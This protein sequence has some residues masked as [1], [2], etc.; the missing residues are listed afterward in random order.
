MGRGPFRTR[1]S[2]PLLSLLKGAGTGYLAAKGAQAEAAEKKKLFDL[3]KR[4][5]D[6]EEEYKKGL[7][8]GNEADRARKEREFKI[9]LLQKRDELA[10]SQWL[11]RK[12]HSL[13]ERAQDSLD[14]NRKD[15]V[16]IR[17]K[18]YGVTE[19]DLKLKREDQ[20]HTQ[21]LEGQN[22]ELDQAKAALDKA[23]NAAKIAEISARIEKITEDIAASKAAT[24]LA[25]RKQGWIEGAQDR[26]DLAANTAFLRK[27]YLQDLGHSQAQELAKL[28]AHL[29]SPALDKMSDSQKFQINQ[30]QETFKVAHE[31]KNPELANR[32][33]EQAKEISKSLKEHGV[34]WPPLMVTVSKKRFW[35]DDVEVHS[36]PSTVIDQPQTQQW[37]VEN[38]IAA[39]KKHGETT[40]TPKDIADMKA[41][42]MSD[43]DIERVKNAFQK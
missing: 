32:S 22:L 34:E 42:G 16:D 9:N 27:K 31:T 14:Q 2:S 38:V 13:A 26:E 41:F 7:I 15:I 29:R 30:W 17:T 12:K 23:D 36:G 11:E 5:L 19:A 4:E 20:K 21:W 37:T 24:L 3:K 1:R 8:R 33:N 18:E 25:E 39:K 6:V 40:V 28:E 35:P 10:E 43:E